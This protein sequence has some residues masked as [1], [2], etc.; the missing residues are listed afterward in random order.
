MTW[1]ILDIVLVVVLALG[2]LRGFVRGMMKELLSLG[3]LFVSFLLATVFYPDITL[4]LRGRFSLQDSAV[5]FAFGGIFLLSFALFKMLEKGLVRI[6]RNTA[7]GGVD[8]LLGML[9]GLL[10]GLVVCFLLVYLIHFQTLVDLSNLSAASF[11][12]PWMER[13]LP[14]LD[15]S[16][17]DALRSAA[18]G[19]GNI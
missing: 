7:L 2:A 3:A 9:F 6:V 8:R 4:W 1:G 10:E 14:S 17:L 5:V 12:M 16:A 15:S 18:A 19:K 11:L 13:V